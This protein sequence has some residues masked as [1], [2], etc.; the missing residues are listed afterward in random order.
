M[1]ALSWT[2][3]VIHFTP[4]PDVDNADMEREL[5]GTDIRDWKNP[6]GL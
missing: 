6:G 3:H 2:S 4:L 5:I 1:S